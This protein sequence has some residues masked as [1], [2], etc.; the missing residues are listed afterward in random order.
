M[1]AAESAGLTAASSADPSASVDSAIRLFLMIN[2]FETGGSER[3]FTVLA[4]NLLPPQ[5]ETHLGCV[6][7]RGPLACNFP[8]VPQ[9]PLGGSL[10]GWQS[11]RTRLK[12]SRHLRDRHA[13]IAHAF[14]F[15]ANLV[16]IPAAR[17]ARVPVVIGSHR[18][19]GDL[20][21]AAQF[22]AQIAAFRWCDAIVC[23]SQAAADRLIAAGLDREKIAIIGNALPADAFAAS[24]AALPKPSGVVRVGMVARMNHGY[25]NHSGFLR[26]A[27]KIHQQN[28]NAEFLLVG[29][30]PLRAELEREAARLG[31]GASATFLGDRQDI[32]AILAS[33]DVA[34]NTSGSESLSNVILEA[35]AA[36]LPVVAYDVGGN[37]ELLTEQR[38]T[39]VSSGDEAGFADAVLRLLADSSVRE[40]LGREARQF[41][42]ENFSLNRVRQRYAELYATL[43]AKKRRGKLRA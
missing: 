34:V 9:F 24:P 39:L 7:H 4:Q 37:S 16:L 42:R 36:G 35:M 43:L 26:I 13:Q 5:F 12:L 10:F 20:M 17:F 33:L 40:R 6:S 11:M 23:N 1:P 3:Q 28:P 32:A 41:A 21:T 2:T 14:D 19:L 22:R 18:Q 25:K 27:A 29:D 15:Y 8:D 38:G 30:G 31:L